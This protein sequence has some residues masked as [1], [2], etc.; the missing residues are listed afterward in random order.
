[1]PVFCAMIFR[2][3][4]ELQYTPIILC[5]FFPCLSQYFD[6]DFYFIWELSA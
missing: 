2:F 6:K 1:M 3:L 4:M 5:G